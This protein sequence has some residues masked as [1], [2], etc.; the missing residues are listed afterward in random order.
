[1]CLSGSLQHASKEP[2]RDTFIESKPMQSYLVPTPLVVASSSSGSVLST[3]A[4]FPTNNKLCS[5]PQFTTSS[6]NVGLQQS[7]KHGAPQV[8]TEVNDVAMPPPN[9][10]RDLPVWPVEGSSPRGPLSYEALVHLRRSASTKKTP[11]CPTIDHTIDL[12]QHPT[13]TMEVIRSNNGNLTQSPSEPSRPKTRPPAVAPKPKMILPSISVQIQNETPTTS[14]SAFSDIHV[15]YPQKV[16]MEALQKLGL[17]KDT[18][19]EDDDV[20]P[21]PPPKTPSSFDP[22]PNR[23]VRDPSLTNPSRSPSFSFTQVPTEQKSRPLQSSASFHHHS[24]R[25]QQTVSASHPAQPHAVKATALERSATLD[26]H[27]KGGYC[28][29]PRPI[30]A[31]EPVKTAAA[32]Q[33]VP[34]KPSNPTGYSVKMVPGMAADR[35][36]AL[37]KLGLLKD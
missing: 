8:P 35:K 36:E 10:P 20:A 23:F 37:R 22:L 15:A 6:N 21:L 13:A 25:E 28:P 26:S 32:A 9:K 5:K 4:G 34:H 31:A 7:Q 18:Q 30:I 2:L 29:E 14:D 1:M 12:A 24:R 16:R 27:K 3:Q 17:L 19:P 33:P 11:L